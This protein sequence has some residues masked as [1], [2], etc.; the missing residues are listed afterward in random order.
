M[1]NARRSSRFV[2]S[3]QRCGS[4]HLLQLD[5]QFHYRSRD[6]TY[7]PE[8]RF[9]SILLLWRILLPLRSMDMVHRPRDQVSQ[10]LIISV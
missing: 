1:V 7:D 5:Q 10:Y 6:S 3:S 8:Y 4:C 2:L 9:G